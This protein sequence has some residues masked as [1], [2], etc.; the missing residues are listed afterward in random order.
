MIVLSNIRGGGEYGPMWHQAALRGNR[1]KSFDDFFAISEDLI[2]RGVT[3][4]KQL[5]AMGRSNGGF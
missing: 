5:G 1:Q 2:K 4:P 3:T